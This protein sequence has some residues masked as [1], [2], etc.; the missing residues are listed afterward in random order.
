MEQSMQPE[1]YQ[2]YLRKI[3]YCKQLDQLSEMVQNILRPTGFGANQVSGVEDLHVSL[4]YAEIAL[5]LKETDQRF[6]Q[7]EIELL[8]FAHQQ[9]AQIKAGQ[10]PD[11]PEAVPTWQMFT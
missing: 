2:S 5:C 10:V 1:H 4:D 9:V 3:R 8:I 7:K 11:E 6:F